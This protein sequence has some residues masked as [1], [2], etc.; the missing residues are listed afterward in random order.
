MRLFVSIP[1]KREST[2]EQIED[3]ITGV[4][5]DDLFQFPSNGKARVNKIRTLNMTLI[6]LFQFPSNGKARVNAQTYAADTS[7]EE[8]QFPSNGKARVNRRIAIIN[9]LKS[10]TFQFPSNGKARVNWIQ[11]PCI[12]TTFCPLKV[13]IPFKRESTCE[14]IHAFLMN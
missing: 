8:F 13:S 1:F 9:Q 5:W 2:C 4:D 10:R 11:D 14:H 7:K 12:H 6:T 3:Y